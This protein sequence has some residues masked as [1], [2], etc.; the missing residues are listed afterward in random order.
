MDG[1]VDD[2]IKDYEET[3][4]NCI[5]AVALTTL[6]PRTAIRV[7]L[8]CLGDDGSL[9]SAL[10]NGA[11]LALLDAGVQLTSVFVGVTC[12]LTGD[13]IVVDPCRREEEAAEALVHY[14]LDSKGKGVLVS[15]CEG[16]FSALQYFRALGLASD[17]CDTLLQFMRQTTCDRFAKS[18]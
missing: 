15:R 17:M 14:V 12:A 18:K 11:A 1:K 10:C 3:L 6:H 2:R 5:S 16:K 9:F 7:V 4:K 13:G 8:Q